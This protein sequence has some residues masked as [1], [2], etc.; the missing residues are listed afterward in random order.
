MTVTRVD[1]MVNAFRRWVEDRMPWYDR[2]AEQANENH[3]TAVIGRAKRATAAPRALT[4]RGSFD[5]AGD[6][7]NR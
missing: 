1:G 7:L 5:R 3:V 2:E 4:M 6:R